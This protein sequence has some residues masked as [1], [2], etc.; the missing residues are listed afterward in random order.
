MKEKLVLTVIVFAV[1]VSLILGLKSI[2][3]PT[4]NRE[5]F[6]ADKVILTESKKVKKSHSFVEQVEEKASIPEIKQRKLAGLFNPTGKNIYKIYECQLKEVCDLKPPYS[7]EIKKELYDY[8][9]LG[10]NDRLGLHVKDEILRKLEKQDK[11][12]EDHLDFLSELSFDQTIDG[13]L[14]GYAVQHLRSEYEK[15]NMDQK[16]KIRKTFKNGIFDIKSD[17]SGTAALAVTAL[18]K[19]YPKEFD[20]ELVNQAVLNLAVNSELHIPSRISAIQSCGELKIIESLPTV[21][22]LA[23]AVKGDKTLRLVA[24]AA[25]GELGSK[26]DILKLEDLI[27]NGHRFFKPA[28]KL[29]IKKLKNKKN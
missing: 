16:E 13:D 18:S 6:N 11:C 5:D 2:M 20:K 1:V 23:Y 8:L 21:Q 29:A 4:K 19:K 26:E 10:N 14:R 28:A 27:V 24:I 17:V 3:S 22:N 9:L 25:L 12:S 15:A 7:E